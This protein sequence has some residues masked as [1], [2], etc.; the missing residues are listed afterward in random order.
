MTGQALLEGESH[1]EGT[2][3]IL[4]GVRDSVTTDAQG[5]FTFDNVPPGTHTVE[6]HRSN[7][8]QA[9]NTLE[10]QPGQTTSV[11]LSLSRRQEALVLQAPALTVQR[12]HLKLT[13]SGFGEARGTSR[14]SIGGVDAEEYLSWSDTEVVVR[15]PGSLVPGEQEVVVTPAWTG[16][17][18][19]PRRCECSGSG[20]SRMRPTGALASCR[21]TPSPS[22]ARPT[23]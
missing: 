5:R 18:P 15:V 14:V 6:A 23:P 21:T 19:P 12:G 3:V 20:P 2:T 16:S 1:H 22:G 10:V 17:P 7:Y 4:S 8:E 13:G 11:D 9:G